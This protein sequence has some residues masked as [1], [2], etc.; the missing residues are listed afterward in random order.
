MP[1]IS[2]YI[3]KTRRNL[4]P[5]INP[6]LIGPR[7]MVY[8]FDLNLK[9]YRENQYEIHQEKEYILFNLLEIIVVIV[10]VV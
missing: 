8:L 5:T 2:C 3:A 4:K 9:Y 1:T 10:V 6:L 7:L